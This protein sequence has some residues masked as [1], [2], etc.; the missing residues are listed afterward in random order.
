LKESEKARNVRLLLAKHQEQ[1][2]QLLQLRAAQEINATMNSH[3]D[4]I[5]VRENSG[6]GITHRKPLTHIA[7][8][9]TVMMFHVRKSG[10]I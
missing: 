8:F 1:V 6:K 7:K 4:E 10:D 5:P 9:T 3:K 2:N